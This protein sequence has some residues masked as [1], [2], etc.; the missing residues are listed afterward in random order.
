M[1]KILTG[2]V[3]STK[4][5][6]TIV[7]AVKSRKTHRIYKKQ[8]SVTNRLMAHD[9]KNSCSV[10]DV[11]QVTETRPIS[12]NKHFNLTTIVARAAIPDDAKIENLEKPLET[13]VEKQEVTIKATKKPKAVTKKVNPKPKEAT[14]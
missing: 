13:T 3:V 11:V 2:T 14:K 5:N 12:R 9:E 1:P 7:I 10:G 6:K 8:Y 4:G